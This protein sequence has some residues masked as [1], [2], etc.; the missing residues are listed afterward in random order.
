[1]PQ[2]F[3]RPPCPPAALEAMQ[4]GR[5]RNFLA[6]SK[7]GND[8]RLC[9]IG[10]LRRYDPWSCR[11]TPWLQ[12]GDPSGLLPC[13]RGDEDRHRSGSRCCRRPRYL[14]AWRCRGGCLPLPGLR[15]PR[16]FTD[17]NATYEYS[18]GVDERIGALAP[19]KLLLTRKCTFRSND[20]DVQYTRLQSVL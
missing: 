13:V 8:G 12:I 20:T 2:A 16:L 6:F 18:S 17:E 15:E 7:L 19:V 11:T 9:H 5:I 4:Q 3:R 1:M 10:L 14:R